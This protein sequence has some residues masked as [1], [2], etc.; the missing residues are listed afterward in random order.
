MFGRFHHLCLVR[1]HPNPATLLIILTLIDFLIRRWFFVCDNQ[2]RWF[3]HIHN[4]YEHGEQVFFSFCKFSSNKQL[5]FILFYEST[6]IVSMLYICLLLVL[7]EEMRAPC[8]HVVAETLAPTNWRTWFM[9]LVNWLPKELSPQVNW[10][11]FWL[12]VVVISTCKVH[13]HIL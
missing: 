10:H 5:L 6:V 1:R 12:D 11:V 3:V 9:G 2:D 4:V 7:I 13:T 8:A